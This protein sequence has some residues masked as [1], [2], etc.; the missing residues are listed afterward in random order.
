MN[1]GELFTISKGKKPP[2]LF[3]I[4]TAT[5][6]PFIKIQ[7]IRSK[8]DHQYCELSD[9]LVICDEGDILLVWDGAYCGLVGFGTKGA[10][11]STIARLRPKSSKVF[12]PYVGHFL[13]SIFKE[14]QKHSIGAAIPHINGGHLR[15]L[16][17][18]L[19]SLM[20]QKKI[21]ALLDKAD[22]LYRQ[23]QESLK[24]TEKLIH[25]IFVDLFIQNPASHTW[26]SRNISWMAEDKKG[27]I[28]TGPFG[29]QLLH[30]EFVDHGVAVLGIDNAVKN[31]FEWGKMRFVTPEK[32]EALKRYKVFPGDLII[33][34]MGTVGRC[35]IIPKNIPDAINSK[36]LCCITLDQSK[37]LPEFL[38]ACLLHHPDVLR[39]LGG[40]IK[41]AVMPGL[42]MRIIKELE[43]PLPPME[44][45]KNFQRIV[46]S[47][48]ESRINLQNSEVGIEALFTTLT[49]RVFQG[50]FEKSWLQKIRPPTDIYTRSK[51]VASSTVGTAS[52]LTSV[53]K[54][55]I[56]TELSLKYL[57]QLI[58]SGDQIQ[59]SAEYFK[60]RILGAQIT[61][62][63][64]NE[65][66]K[67]AESVFD[68]PPPYE[69]IK[70]MILNLVSCGEGS[71]HITQTFDEDRK[72][73]VLKTTP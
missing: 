51:E 33:T 50:N 66:M 63:T 46:A 35:A 20:T 12:G 26:I 47:I 49:Q 54:V 45:Q 52:Q 59:W 11:G 64:F 44:L 42:N 37:C 55:P 24:L 48:T 57:D 40:R 19:P 2:T 38:Q 3:D 60:Y 31:R 6:I 58:E 8:E 21:S 22:E 32:Y 23:R 27:A 30:S 34:I 70:D 25:S 4:P 13:R 61:S 16:E 9:E 41:G 65:V 69:E 14:L 62:F 15:R 39:Q 72:E 7:G 53:I 56:E 73:V 71:F 67:K 28:R 1:I 43:L 68:E 10:I 18:P 5:S 17:I 36:H 29:S